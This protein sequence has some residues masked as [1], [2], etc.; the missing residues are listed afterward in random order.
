M[1]KL[2]EIKVPLDFEG[3]ATH[4]IE[5]DPALDTVTLKGQNGEYEA[6]PVKENGKVFYL[7]LSNKTLIRALQAISTP[8]KLSIT[9]KGTGFDT[10]Y[11]VK[12]AK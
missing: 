8:A 10:E 4:V 11:E 9:R 1:G 3:S 7:A 12:A 6:I 2:S 5:F